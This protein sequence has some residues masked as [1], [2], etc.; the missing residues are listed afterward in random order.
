MHRTRNA[1]YGQ[2]YRG[3]E[4]LPLR[5]CC[6]A[7]KILWIKR[8]RRS[9]ITASFSPQR[10]E[11]LGTVKIDGDTAT[12]LAS[13]IHNHETRDGK[14]NLIDAGY[15]HDQWVRTPEGWRIKH[16]KHQ[17]LYTNTFPVIDGPAFLR[18]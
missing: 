12:S 6:G 15:W 8:P 3:F 7:P 1:A 2:P 14:A 10:S 18:D 5:Q 4:S 9:P 11:H 16:R 17:K 13:Y